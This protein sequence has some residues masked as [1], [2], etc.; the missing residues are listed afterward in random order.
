MDKQQA[1]A[2]LDQASPGLASL[3]QPAQLRAALR[4]NDRLKL[5]LSVL[6]AALAHAR[7][8]REPAVFHISP[9]ALLTVRVHV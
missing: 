4:A 3:L 9:A 2:S 8:P 7:A 6:Q 5:Y 1:V